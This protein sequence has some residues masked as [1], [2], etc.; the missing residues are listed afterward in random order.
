MNRDA[1]SLSKLFMFRQIPPK[2]LSKLCSVAHPVSFGTGDILYRQGEPSTGALLIVSGK[3]TAYIGLGEKER[4]LGDSRPGE[5]VGETGIFFKGSAR[6]ATV[7]ATEPTRCL[8]IDDEL[9]KMT[10]NNQAVVALETYLISSIARRIR[11]TGQTIQM[12]WREGE[13]TPKVTTKNAK[14]VS[15]REK[16]NNFFGGAK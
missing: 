15:L 7:R 9:L 11:K 6:T 2:E 16:L 13:K 5:I 1:E 3:L 4:T 10:S 12:F 14:P 8:F